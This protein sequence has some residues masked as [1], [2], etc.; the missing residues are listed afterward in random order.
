M[1][2][3]FPHNGDRKYGFVEGFGHDMVIVSFYLNGKP[4]GKTVKFS[5]IEIVDD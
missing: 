4:Q 5:D 3:T 2:V 1:A